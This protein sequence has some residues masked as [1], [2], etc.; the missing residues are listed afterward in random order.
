M[1]GTTELYNGKLNA[2]TA[3]KETTGLDAGASRTLKFEY[4]IA[5]TVGNEIQGDNCTFDIVAQLDQ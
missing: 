4:L 2:F 5:S 1:D 3:F